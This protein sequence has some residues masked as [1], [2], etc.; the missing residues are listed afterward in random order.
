MEFRI[1]GPVE[2]HGDDGPVRLG[3]AKHRTVLAV[4]LLHA[5][6]VV[7]AD[8]LVD[9]LWGEEPPN[10]AANA[11]QVYVSQLRKA[12]GPGASIRR[13]PPGYA[14]EIGPEEL[15]L[16][17]FERLAEEGRRAFA[18][19]ETSEAA[20]KLRDALRLWR[21]PALSD[22][23][24]ESSGAVEARRLEDA[25]LAVVEDRIEAD[26]ALGRHAEL[27]P[28][29]EALV[30]EHPLRERFRHQLMVALYRAGRQ[31]DALAA[32][33]DARRAL[34]E[35][36]GIDPSPALQE[37]EKAILNQDPRLAAPPSAP[38]Q[39]PA[40]SR[41]PVPATPLVG[42][43]E[44]LNRV[45]ALARRD[46]VRLVTLTGA[47]GIGKTR[48]ALE[49]AR[50][51]ADDY[52]DGAF[53]VP[54]GTIAE[55]ALVEP[56]IATSLGIVAEG[57]PEHEAVRS[58]LRDRSLLLVLD[59]FEQVL[60][61]AAA[62]ADLLASAPGVNLFVTSRAVLRLSGEYE[63][64]VGPLAL[65]RPGGD[66]TESPAVALFV[67]RAA[68]ALPDF[69]L[70]GDAGA[71]AELCARLEGIPLAIEL[72]AARAKLLTPRAMLARLASRLD[73]PAAAAQDVPARQQTL[74][75]TLDWS[76]GLL[77]EPDRRVFAWLGIFAGGCT[78]ETAEAVVGDGV[79]VLGAVASL[80]DK[81]LVRRESG[82]EPR[83][84]MLEVVREY[85]L[86]RL[87]ESGEGE[88]AARKHL[89]HYL[90][91]AEEAVEHL[92][93][94][95]QAAWLKR[96]EAEHDNIRRA[97]AFALEAKDDH[98][99]LRFASALGWFWHVRGH[100]ADGRRL[101]E[102]ALALTPDER[103]VTRARALNAAG[104]LSAEQGDYEAAR[105]FFT[106]SLELAREL[107]TPERVAAALSNLGNLSLFEHR[108]EEALA[109][110]EDVREM[111]ERLGQPRNLAVVVENVAS[112]ALRVRDLDRALAAGEESVTLARETSD[113][114]QLASSLEALAQIYFVRGDHE[115][116]AAALDESVSIARRLGEPRAEA[117]CLDGFAALAAAT[118]DPDRAVELLGA[119]DALR[120]SIGARR[121]PDQQEWYEA[122]A[123]IGA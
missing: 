92:A 115:A 14:L 112:A 46:D 28:E 91:L 7:S 68:A 20:A 101:V 110:Y 111:W 71:V 30:A 10:T 5:N 82:R 39:R 6:E 97:V 116:A 35:E 88:Q 47:G 38:M 69:D 53:F 45:L 62:L 9:E 76:Y 22:V 50:T 104:Y 60:P 16:A 56:T 83:F 24:L 80:V 63:F 37:L 74:R 43:D 29:L 102:A 103:S 79:D 49:A 58:F 48:L 89:E 21:G 70:D 25:R 96:L 93:G 86:E 95:D 117:N 13:Q 4:L 105:R 98:V 72:A 64:P 81:S 42:R 12:L 66:P 122:T 65:P 23:T 120:E 73:L 108:Y 67:Q 57:Q 34:V 99:A 119:A 84:G 27:V 33:Q 75:A 2:V 36:L 55:P 114:H 77:D 32:Y 107:D 40:A 85:A 78:L 31:A 118:G 3:G 17:R 121:S 100:L 61:A 90:A 41:L 8:R 52:A 113:F 54:L 109:A 94:A 44:E 15:D 26:L 87:A 123:G 19:G 18:A 1:L 11:L 51:I 106:A 59:N